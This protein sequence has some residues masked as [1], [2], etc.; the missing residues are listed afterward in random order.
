MNGKTTHAAQVA[1]AMSAPAVRSTSFQRE[2]K[3]GVLK[4]LNPLD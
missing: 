4:Q 1:A 2:Q 3:D